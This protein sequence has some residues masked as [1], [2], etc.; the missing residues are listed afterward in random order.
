MILTFTFKS[1]VSS[2]SHE[3]QPLLAC[4]PKERFLGV[5][6]KKMYKVKV[7][8]FKVFN[9]KTLNLNIT[10]LELKIEV[11][12]RMFRELKIYY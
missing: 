8:I 11:Y 7:E 5:L 12:N 1:L 2:N 10:C 4:N 9:V 6:H 3:L